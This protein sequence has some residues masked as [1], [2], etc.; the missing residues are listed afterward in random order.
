MRPR[1]ITVMASQ[2]FGQDSKVISPEAQ[3][4][5]AAST[6][7]PRSPNPALWPWSNDHGSDRAVP[8]SGCRMLPSNLCKPGYLCAARSTT[9]A[10]QTSGSEYGSRLRRYGRMPWCALFPGTKAGTEMKW[11]LSSVSLVAKNVVPGPDI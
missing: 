4:G 7:R 6:D 3:V 9:R 2:N 1:V 8:V 5:T 11:S 10:N